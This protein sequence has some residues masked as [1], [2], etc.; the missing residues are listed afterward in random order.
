MGWSFFLCE[1]EISRNC[2]IFS[3][4]GVRFSGIA[5]PPDVVTW[6]GRARFS[7]TSDF[8]GMAFQVDASEKI[9]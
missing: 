7:G 6:A 2:A 1:L 8:L 4:I 3:G 5:F 9:G